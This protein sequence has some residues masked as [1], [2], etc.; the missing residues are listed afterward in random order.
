M[1][2]IPKENIHA[3]HTLYSNRIKAIRPEVQEI[4]ERGTRLGP[5]YEEEAMA[6]LA[7]LEEELDG[8]EEGIKILNFLLRRG[9]GS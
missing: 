6:E 1:I 7:A 4:A 2:E 3:A 9:H 8:L 5:E